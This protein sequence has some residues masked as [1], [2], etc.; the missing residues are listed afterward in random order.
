MER[1]KQY[2][3]HPEPVINLAA[4]RLIVTGY[5]L[6]HMVASEYLADLHQRALLPEA[7]YGPLPVL[8][9]LTMSLGMGYRPPVEVLTAI[10]WVTMLAGILAWIGLKTNLSLFLFAIG[11]IFIIAYNYSFGDFHHP[12]A[13]MLIT[14][15]ILSFSPAG[16][17]LSADHLLERRRS[18]K[19]PGD[20]VGASD[21]TVAES[22]FA[23]WPLQLVKWLFVLIYFSATFSKIVGNG[24][25]WFNGYTLQYYLMRDGLRW[26]SSLGIWIS[27]YHW[28]AI[29]LSITTIFF[30]ATF[31]LAVL[32]PRLAVLYIPLGIALHLGIYLTMR[33]PFFQY[34]AVYSVFIPWSRIT[35]ALPLRWR[36]E[37]YPLPR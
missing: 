28:L 27:Q 15:L 24:A 1:W 7:L 26:G 10:F 18:R 14:L 4:V 9:L 32:F 25:D 30:E 33:A 31:F 19:K 11:N 34:I 2:W 12:Q 5:Q 21:F 36:R 3:F 16:R 17:V 8:R 29:L 37:A 6:Y 13:I 35:P 20:Q 22:T 23:A